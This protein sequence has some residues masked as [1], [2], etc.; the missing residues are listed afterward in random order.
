M[1][2]DLI[3]ASDVP[4]GPTSNR[5]MPAGLGYLL[6]SDDKPLWKVKSMSDVGVV[7]EDELARIIATYGNRTH[8][9]VQ[10]SVRGSLVGSPT[11][12]KLSTGLVSMFPLA[13][14]HDWREDVT[15]ITMIE[16]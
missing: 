5:H 16:I 4:Y 6:D 9:L 15:T 13:V 3:F 1:N 11:P 2:V 12:D 10:L 7:A 14:S 8:R